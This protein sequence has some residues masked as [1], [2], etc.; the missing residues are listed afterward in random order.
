FIG[1]LVLMLGAIYV[2]FSTSVP[3]WNKLFGLNM[4]PPVDEKFHY[5]KV[6]IFIAILIALGTATVQFLNYRK[7]KNK[8]TWKNLWKPTLLSLIIGSL[9]VFIGDV[10]FYDHG[11]GFLIA[12]DLLVYSSVYAIIANASYMTTALKGKMKKAGASVAHLG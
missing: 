4:A 7:N 5:N 10:Y 3:V 2:T 9:V 11:I 1:A 12:I 8:K 6:M